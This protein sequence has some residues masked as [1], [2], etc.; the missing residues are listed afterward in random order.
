[1]SEKQTKSS[2]KESKSQERKQEKRNQNRQ[3]KNIKV[4]VVRPPLGPKW[5][6]GHKKRR[7]GIGIETVEQGLKQLNGHH[8]V[9]K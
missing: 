1:M 2:K 4:L 3:V 6:R 8:L 7:I 9:P 5:P